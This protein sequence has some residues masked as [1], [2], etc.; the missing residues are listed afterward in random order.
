MKHFYWVQSIYLPYDGDIKASRQLIR[1]ASN[2]K[3]T[4][5]GFTVPLTFVKQNFD[6]KAILLNISVRSM[7]FS[8]IY[9]D[10]NNPHTVLTT[11]SVTRLNG[12]IPVH[13]H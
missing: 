13:N 10:H 4:I 9:L 2:D 1:K 6:L 5:T 12:M 8:K 11:H 7:R 3:A